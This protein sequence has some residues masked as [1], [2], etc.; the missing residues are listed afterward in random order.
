[1]VDRM[2]AIRILQ[3]LNKNY[4]R[5]M[6]QKEIR[7]EL[8]KENCKTNEKTL[9]L[10]IRDLIDIL[11]PK[12]YKEGENDD[13]FILK[14]N[15]WQSD[16]MPNKITNIYISPRISGYDA[17]KLYKGVCLLDTISDKDKETLLKK[18]KTEFKINPDINRDVF[19]V[20]SDTT[21]NL[22]N[23]IDV[24]LKAISHKK[25]IT[26]QF[27]GYDEKMV[28]QPTLKNGKP[29]I[30]T[31]SPYYI[32][33]YNGKYY[34]IA[35]T[36]GYDNASIYRVD[37]MHDIK[38]ID[39]HSRQIREINEL[40]QHLSVG[41]YVKKH[42]NMMYGQ[43]R[44][45]HLKV[46]NDSYTLIYDYFRDF[47]F[48]KKLNKDYDEITVTAS[49]KAVFDLAMTAFDRVEVIRPCRERFIERLNNIKEKYK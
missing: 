29:K 7:E 15:G 11:N 13:E 31:I 12:E 36:V 20:T 17:E 38:I 21:E 32:V 35:N 46:R 16:K 9:S 44:E 26:F 40:N 39:E 18:L 25:Q 43:E 3:I 8:E 14:Y 19:V 33:K 4:N 34:T 48:I 42:I 45:F 22:N 5:H 41:D 47:E 24:I 23:N 1:M 6:S 49:E 10:A 27:C 2:R 28:L 30:Y 37:L